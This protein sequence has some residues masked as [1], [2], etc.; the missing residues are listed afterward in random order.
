APH[1]DAREPALHGD[2]GRHRDHRRNRR[3]RPE[4]EGRNG[5]G[6]SRDRPDL[7]GPHRQSFD[8]ARLSEYPDR[9]GMRR[10]A[11]AL[12]FLA[13]PA[14]AQDEPKPAPPPAPPPDP[15]PAATT[16]KVAD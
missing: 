11:I 9:F 5:R 7:P 1:R 6:L 12:V 14:L 16:P 3:G 8:E 4:R 2:H 13:T 15:P 10:S